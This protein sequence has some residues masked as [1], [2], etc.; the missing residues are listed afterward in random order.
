[1][2]PTRNSPACTSD[3]DNNEETDKLNSIATVLRAVMKTPFLDMAHLHKSLG[4]A[5]EA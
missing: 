2:L 1:M 3:D 4:G 5:A